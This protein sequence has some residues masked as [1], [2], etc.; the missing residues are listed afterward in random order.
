MCENETKAKTKLK[1]L[2]SL[3]TLIKSDFKIFNSI[4]H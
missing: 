4:K 3:K 1:S 2:F